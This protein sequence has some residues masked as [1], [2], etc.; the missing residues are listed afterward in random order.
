M[1]TLTRAESFDCMQRHSSQ[2]GSRKIMYA[3]ATF[4]A[5]LEC[6]TL[7]REPIWTTCQTL[8]R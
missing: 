3:V 4:D 1:H 5:E 7:P 2:K 6:L 8:P